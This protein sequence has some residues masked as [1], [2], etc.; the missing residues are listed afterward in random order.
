MS[1]IKPGEMLV[2]IGTLGAAK[3]TLRQLLTTLRFYC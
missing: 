3:T 1:N 2:V